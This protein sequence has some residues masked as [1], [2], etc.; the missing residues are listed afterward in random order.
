[1]RIALTFALLMA[2]TPLAAQVPKIGIVDVYG[3]RTLTADQ[4]RRAAR[5]AV[6][7]SVTNRTKAD[8]VARL[9]ALPNVRAAEVDI[10]CCE[11]GQSIA[12]IGVREGSDSVATSYATAPTGDA[13]LP[14]NII[15]ADE[16]YMAALQ[17]A[18][19]SGDTGESDSL[20]HSLVNYVPA[21]AAQERFIA[22]AA[23]NV[24][25]LRDVLHT[26]SDAHHRALAAQVIA[27]AINKN[28]V[29]PDL[30]RAL[31]D[32]AADVRNNATRALAVMAM[33]NQRNPQAMLRVP[34]QPFIE[35]LNSTFWTDR[36]KASF[37][38][39]ALATA[40][41]VPLLNALRARAF[42][43]LADMVRWESTGHAMPAALILGRMGG[44][45][46]DAIMQGMQG[47]RTR[48]IEAARA[49]R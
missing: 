15:A 49:R 13:R 14:T 32:P 16:E 45:P 33:Y 43:S 18:V 46:D 38:L 22:Y 24:P 9:R 1:M 7:D 30:V 39:M 27:Y 19:V 10:V 29:I 42:D 40:E 25:R 41:N 31:R 28:D 26:S 35:L 20:G 4:L 23:G 11:N 8:A 34:Y 37:V 6:G 47:D 48:I 2:A 21:R 5:I 36:N 12:Y 44:L 17:Q 3:A